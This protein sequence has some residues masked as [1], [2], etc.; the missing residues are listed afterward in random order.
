MST[1][2]DLLS[3]AAW[4]YEASKFGVMIILAQADL[5]AKVA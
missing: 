3:P 2:Q 4:R 5:A 1:L